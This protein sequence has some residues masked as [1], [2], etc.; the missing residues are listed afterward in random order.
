MLLF[1]EGIIILI[2][3][4]S[5]IILITEE[6]RIKKQGVSRGTIKEYWNGKERRQ[7]QRLNASVFVKY[8]IEKKPHIKLAGHTKDVSSSGMGL[9]VNEKLYEGTLLLLEF[10]LPELK[11]AVCAEGKVVWVK[12]DLADRNK[13]GKRE[14]QAGIQFLN[15][16]ADDKNRL[17]AYIEKNLEG[18]AGL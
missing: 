11:N 17:I 6:R 7:A 13:T 2:L 10:E 18:G 8:S 1:I 9:V 4:A 3:I 16:K 14:F 15:I 12:G 5:V